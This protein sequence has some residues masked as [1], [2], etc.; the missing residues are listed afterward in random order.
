ML[1]NNSYDNNQD[2]TT[3][4]TFLKSLEVLLHPLL[5]RRSYSS[6][7]GLACI[8]EGGGEAF[9]RGPDDSHGNPF[10]IPRQPTESRINHGAPAPRG[11]R[12]NPVFVQA[13]APSSRLA[14]LREEHSQS[15]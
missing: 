15:P 10:L 3:D 6:E 7:L 9:L 13:L 4:T 12:P 14:Q 2:L 11:P 5:R 1:C 8:T